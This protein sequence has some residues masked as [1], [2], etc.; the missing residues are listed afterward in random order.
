MDGSC[1]WTIVNGWGAGTDG[2]ETVWN[3]YQASRLLRR[4]WMPL[5]WVGPRPER[6]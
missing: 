4:R 1:L 2:T 3:D 5:V 6:E